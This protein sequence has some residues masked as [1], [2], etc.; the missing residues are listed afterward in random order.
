MNAREQRSAW[1]AEAVKWRLQSQFM[2]GD[3]MS[4]GE[5]PRATPTIEAIIDK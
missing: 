3:P 5:A 2:P 4:F 1:S